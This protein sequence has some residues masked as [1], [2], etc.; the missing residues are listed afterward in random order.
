MSEQNKA[1]LDL[2]KGRAFWSNPKY[3]C[4]FKFFVRDLSVK[5]SLGNQ[6]MYV[7]FINHAHIISFNKFTCKSIC[8]YMVTIQFEVVQRKNA[9]YTTRLHNLPISLLSVVPNRSSYL[10]LHIKDYVYHLFDLY[11]HSKLWT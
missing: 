10:I 1:L 9:I 11:L 7:L 6:H 5:Q 2:P 3:I 8:Y 4:S